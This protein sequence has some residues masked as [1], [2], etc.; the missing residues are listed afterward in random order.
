MI[1]VDPEVNPDLLLLRDKQVCPRGSQTTVTLS[2]NKRRSDP[3]GDGEMLF[4]SFSNLT[5]RS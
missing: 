4:S 2:L 1:T 5:N 3:Q